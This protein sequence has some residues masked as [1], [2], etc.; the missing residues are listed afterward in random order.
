MTSGNG[1]YCPLNMLRMTQNECA[2]HRPRPED[3]RDGAPGITLPARSKSGSSR[4]DADAS[5]REA[6]GQ[7]NRTQVVAF[8][9]HPRRFRLSKCIMEYSQSVLRRV[10][11]E[12][13]DLEVAE[14]VGLRVADPYAV[15]RQFDASA[16]DIFLAPVRAS[17]E[18]IA[19][20]EAQVCS[21]QVPIKD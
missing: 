8:M 6:V 19:A 16:L 5:L 11:L 18:Y 3:A 20:D 7:R 17:P 21:P 13:V 1:A 10:P 2:R 9:Q 14:V 15:D 12:S 4:R